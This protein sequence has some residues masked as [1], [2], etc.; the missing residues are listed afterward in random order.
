MLKVYHSLKK[1]NYPKIK[2]RLCWMWLYLMIKYF[3]KIFVLPLS[4]RFVIKT[5]KCSN[6]LFKFFIFF[7]WYS[8]PT[9]PCHLYILSLQFISQPKDFIIFTH[10]FWSKITLLSSW[11]VFLCSQMLNNAGFLWWEAITN[12]RYDNFFISGTE[13]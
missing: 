8:W 3:M 1:W 6:R 5:R 12:A 9:F 13:Q 11:I 7:Q 4:F 2:T 10:N